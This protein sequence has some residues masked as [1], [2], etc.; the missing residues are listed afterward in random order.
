M[1]NKLFGKKNDGFYMQIDESAPPQA[2]TPKTEAPKTAPAKAKFPTFGKSKDKSQEAAATSAAPPAT[3]SAATQTAVIVAEPAASDPA[4]KEQSE[5]KAKSA[6]T[7]IKDKKDKSKKEKKAEEPIAVT[8]TPTA[9]PQPATPAIT[10]FATDYLVTAAV[11]G[12]RRRPGAN[13][14]GFM[15]MAR[16]VKEM[17]KGSQGSQLKQK[18]AEKTKTEA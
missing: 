18:A 10:N 1:F 12:N 11:A 3:S 17:K 2:E 8:Q 14:K 9:I 16:D 5:S 4:A 7:S 6:K 15:T 13:M